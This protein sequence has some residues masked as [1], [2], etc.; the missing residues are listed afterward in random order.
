[1]GSALTNH[2]V[3]HKRSLWDRDLQRFEST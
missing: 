2:S 3:W 1:M